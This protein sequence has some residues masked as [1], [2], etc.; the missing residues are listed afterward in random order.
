MKKIFAI[1]ALFAF[2]IGIAPTTV[3]TPAQ[4]F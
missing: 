1:L 2:A 4:A 3:V